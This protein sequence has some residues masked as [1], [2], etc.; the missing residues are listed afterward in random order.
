MTILY[1]LQSQI[2]LADFCMGRLFQC[3]VNKGH[4]PRLCGFTSCR[5]ADQIEKELFIETELFN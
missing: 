4:L 2:P 3:V 5:L 1:Y